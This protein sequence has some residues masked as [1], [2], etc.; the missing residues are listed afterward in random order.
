MNDK[1]VSR[2]QLTGES[3]YSFCPY[4]VKEAK[5]RGE[6]Y[7]TLPPLFRIV[8]AKHM[9]GFEHDYLETK[10]ECPKCKKISTLDTFLEFY[11]QP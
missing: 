9:P 4:C 10:Y 5:E 7:K 3:L 1:L 2:T 11:T 8:I 6:D